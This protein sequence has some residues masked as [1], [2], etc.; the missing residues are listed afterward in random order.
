MDRLKLSRIAVKKASALRIKYGYSMDEGLCP[1]DLAIKLKVPVHI[2]SYPSLEGMYSPS[3]NNVIIVGSERPTGRKRFSCAHE[4]GHHI[5]EH[6]YKLDELS[7]KTQYD[8]DE[9]L[10]DRFASALILPKI[11]LM[12]VV[13]GRNWNINNLSAEEVYRLANDFGVGYE[14]ILVNLAMNFN[15]LERKNFEALKK[16]QLPQIREKL[17][18]ERKNNNIFL[19]DS[20]FPR[21]FVDIEIDDYLAFLTPTE[22]IISDKMV[23]SGDGFLACKTGELNVTDKNG[24][25]HTIRISRKGYE[26]LARYRHLEDFLDE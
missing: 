15:S 16:V 10:A 7:D 9:F 13:N 6:G 23:K 4:I 18:K 24:K 20:F 2:K 26:G 1:Y 25:T 8:E 12:K 14:T 3:P 17:C 22:E 19:I 21:R 5:F 11:A